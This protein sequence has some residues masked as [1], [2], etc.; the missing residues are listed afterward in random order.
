[1]I[2]NVVAMAPVY[3][4]DPYAEEHLVDPYPLFARML[5]EDSAVWLS[6]HE[7]HAFTHFDAVHDILVDHETFISG[8]GVGPANLHVTQIGRAHV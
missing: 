3:D 8:A 5:A 6:Q 2:G 7:V 4:D 1:M